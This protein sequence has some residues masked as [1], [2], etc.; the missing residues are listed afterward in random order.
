MISIRPS[1]VGMSTCVGESG[2]MNTAFEPAEVAL[3]PAA[4]TALTVQVYVMPVV[5][6]DTKIG[7]P[8]PLPVTGAPPPTGVHATV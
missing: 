3:V 6:P 7:L 1:R 8:L 2:L 5:R 4:F